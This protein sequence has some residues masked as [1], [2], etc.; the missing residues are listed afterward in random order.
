MKLRKNKLLYIS[1]ILFLHMKDVNK[2]TSCAKSE[3]DRSRYKI[4]SERAGKH[5]IRATL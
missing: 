2:K 5:C 3:R 1:H 4:Q